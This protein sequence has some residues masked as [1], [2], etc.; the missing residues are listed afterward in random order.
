MVVSDEDYPTV[1]GKKGMNARL[2]GHMIG[3]EIDV[4]K[5]TEYH[6]LLAIQM[7]E[8]ADSSEPAYDERLRIEGVSGLI[9]ESLIGAGYETLRKFM[10]AQPGEISTK[11]P[12]VNY[13]DLADKILEQTR[14]KKV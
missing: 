5:L 11:V 12:G 7:A 8:L 4:Q 6:K 1:I 10:L 9:L 2:V 14:K 13:Y 3:K